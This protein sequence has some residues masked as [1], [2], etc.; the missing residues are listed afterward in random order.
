V[1]GTITS[2]KVP[3]PG[4]PTRVAPLLVSVLAIS[5]RSSVGAHRV[6]QNGRAIDRGKGEI[7]ALALGRG[8]QRAGIFAQ[9]NAHAALEVTRQRLVAQGSAIVG[10]VDR[11]GQPRRSVFE[12]GGLREIGI[13]PHHQVARPRGHGNVTVP[14]PPS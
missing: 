6:G 4:M 11:R 13:E 8:G 10:Q 7:L 12:R 5:A 3:P 9:R 14:P 1:S 2:C